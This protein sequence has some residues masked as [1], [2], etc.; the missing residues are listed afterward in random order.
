[1]SPSSYATYEY[2]IWADILGWCISFSCVLAVPIRAAILIAGKSGP[3][4]ARIQQL[5]RPAADWGPIDR[6]RPVETNL[7]FVD[8]KTPLAND[9]ELYEMERE[10]SYLGRHGGDWEEDED[11][12]LHMKVPKRTNL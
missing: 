2:P 9:E 10:S 4:W 5:I 12:G 7:N 8:S 11:D 3:I 6:R 1:Y